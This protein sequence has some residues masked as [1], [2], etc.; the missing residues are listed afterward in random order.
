VPCQRTDEVSCGFCV[1][2]KNAILTSSA[3]R[4]SSKQ[5]QNYRAIDARRP[6]VGAS[7][8]Q[9]SVSGAANVTLRVFCDEL[10]HPKIGDL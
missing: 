7:C 8:R 10:S 4:R 2:A 9:N 5:E 1:G 3:R 6:E